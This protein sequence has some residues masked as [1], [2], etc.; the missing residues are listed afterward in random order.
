[1][2]IKWA[3]KECTDV[4]GFVG[5][6]KYISSNGVKINK[7]MSLCDTKIR[8]TKRQRIKRAKE[9]MK[10]SD[11]EIYYVLPTPHFSPL[12]QKGSNN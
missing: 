2:T 4:S 9:I 3:D 11:A 8:R 1:M 10:N 6:Q 5:R 7:A 12:L